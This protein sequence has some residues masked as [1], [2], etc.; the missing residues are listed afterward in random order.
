MSSTNRLPEKPQFSPYE[1]MITKI[2]SRD[3]SP[4][5]VP[6]EIKK[7]ILEAAR[8]TGS[9]MNAQHWRFILVQD[10]SNLKQ[11]ASD[12]TT[13]AWVVNAS[14]AVIVLTDPKYRFHMIDAG[15]AIQSMMLAAWS[16]DV[17]SGIYIGLDTK[18]M[19]SDFSLPKD[20]NI[21]AVVA[22]GYPLR[23]I[24]GKKPE[25]Q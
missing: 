3:F 2:E 19:T 15:R 9:G 17:A 25:N 11:L 21:A 22:F 14:F 1:R 18:A 23:K 7:K 8:L 5:P 10:K 4:E 13:G 6:V 24:V 12:S 20:L 16:F